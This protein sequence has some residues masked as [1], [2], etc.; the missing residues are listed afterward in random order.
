MHDDWIRIK[1]EHGP[2]SGIDSNSD[3]STRDDIS[4]HG[5]AAGRGH[6]AFHPHGLSEVPGLAHGHAQAF[7]AAFDKFCRGD[8]SFPG[9][10]LNFR[11]GRVALHIQLVVNAARDCCTRNETKRKEQQQN[12]VHGVGQTTQLDCA[13]YKKKPFSASGWLTPAMSSCFLHGRENGRAIEG[14]NSPL[15]RQCQR[16]Y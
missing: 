11:A 5:C 15:A 4:S 14:S 8:A 7:S 2:G 3:D 12:L 16:V 10:K 13:G 6:F 9:R 1:P